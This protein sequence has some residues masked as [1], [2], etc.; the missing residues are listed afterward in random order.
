[1]KKQKKLGFTGFMVV[2]FLFIVIVTQCSDEKEPATTKTEPPVAE[3][4]YIVPAPPGSENWPSFRGLNGTG[5]SGDQDLPLNWDVKTGTNIKWQAKIPGLGHSSPVVWQ[6]RV[7][8]TTAVG[9]DEEPYLKVGL[10]GESPDNPEDYPHSYIVYCFDR[11]S[12]KKMWEKTSFKGKPK[13]KRH[14]KSSH[15]NCTIATDGK[16]VVA[17]FGSQGLYCYTIDGELLWKK[18]LGYLDAGAFDLPEIQWGFGNSPLIYQDKLLIL[19]DVNNQSFVAQFDVATGKEIWRTLRDENP[20][21]GTPAVFKSK[22]GLQIIVNGYK[23]IG[24]YDF[25]TGK[26]IWWLRGG[27]DVPVPTPVVSD[28]LV[29]ITNAHGRLRPIYAISLDAKGDVSLKK[30]EKSNQYIKWYKPRKGAYLNTPLVYGD[31]LYVGRGNGVLTC[32]HKKTGEKVYKERI[33]GQRNSYSSSAVAADGRLYFSDEQGN[34]HIIK[35]GPK[36]K[37]LSTNKLGESCLATPAISG[38]MIFIRTYRHLFAIKKGSQSTGVVTK[39][40]AEKEDK[41]PDTTIS[42][43]NLKTD[44]S[45]KDPTEIL[46][47]VDLKSTAV[48]TVNYDVVVKGTGALKPIVGSLK[49]NITASGLLD[50]FPKLM[51]VKGE[52]VTPGSDKPIKFTGGA[53]GKDYFIIN[54]VDKTARVDIELGGL[55]PL[56]NYFL[57]GILR[58]FHVDKPFTDEV[59]SEQKVLH[60]LKD[61]EGERCYEI[62]VVYSAEHNYKATWFISVKDFLPRGRIDYRTMPNKQKGEIHKFIKNL[63]LKPKIDPQ[64]FKFQ[65]PEGYKKKEE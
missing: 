8:I 65:L 37:H 26:P 54:H 59:N 13:V 61:I 12:G 18:D 39:P 16:H 45:M 36:Y 23:H 14:V 25:A 38:K 1:M 29:Y 28:G 30:D 10:Y 43:E 9:E 64:I 34:I 20:T 53:D 46:K 52:A 5:I 2:L 35:A 58:E 32:Y 62:E 44:G 24:S 17:F 21:W 19:A 3:K 48:K 4:E 50:G 33:A 55:G 47:I 42:L 60:G 15:A 40:L 56:V 27:G 31:Y 6:N 51:L 22:D 7:F 49:A 41:K 63:S 57:G 11:D